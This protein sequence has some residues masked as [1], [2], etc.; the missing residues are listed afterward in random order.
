MALHKKLKKI[1]LTDVSM[2]DISWWSSFSIAFNGRSTNPRP[3]YGHKIYSDSS[4]KGFAALMGDDWFIGTWETNNDKLSD[5]CN[6]CTHLVSSPALDIYDTSN[7]NE[8]EFWPVLLAIKRW[9]PQLR[10]SSITCVTDNQQVLNILKSGRSSNKTCMEWVKELFWVCALNA[11]D[12]KSEYIRSENNVWADHLSRIMYPKNA[13][14][15]ISL[16][17]QTQLCCKGR[18]LSCCRS[19]VGSNPD[20]KPTSPNASSGSQHDESSA[21]TMEL[22][23]EILC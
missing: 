14:E 11:I 8:L 20:Q 6:Y 5:L 3:E 16:V 1:R 12:I 2:S 4:M 17:G 15:M 22:L 19:I 23:P 21:D 10:S 7:I 9:L 18:L 13:N